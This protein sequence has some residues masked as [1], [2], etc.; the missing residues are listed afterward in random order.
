MTQ[1]ENQAVHDALAAVLSE[2]CEMEKSD[3][4]SIYIKRHKLGSDPTSRRCDVEA[5]ALAEIM[6]GYGLR[7]EQW[8]QEHDKN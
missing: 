3:M 7:F 4:F 6:E 1:Q 2:F 8:S 5:A